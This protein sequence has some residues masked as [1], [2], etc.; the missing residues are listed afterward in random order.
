MR[1]LD[2]Q[3]YLAKEKTP[4]WSGEQDE[5]TKV[6]TEDKIGPETVRCSEWRTVVAR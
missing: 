2:S 4:G 1:K 3:R 5:L 6:R